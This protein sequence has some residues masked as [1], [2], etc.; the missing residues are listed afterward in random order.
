MSFKLGHGFTLIELLVVVLIIAILAAVALPQYQKVVL[1]SRYHSVMPMVDSIAQA[2]QLYFLEHGEYTSSLKD[3]MM[4]A[5][6]AH[7]SPWASCYRALSAQYVYC[8]VY[9]SPH[10]N[11]VVSYLRYFHN[12]VRKCVA[13]GGET[14]SLGYELCQRET[15]DPNPVNNWFTYP[16]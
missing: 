14:N 2:E 4:G 15:K 8:V 6:T 10:G 11:Q 9:D 13:Y 3:L 1:K 16:N 5:N 12:N 7:I